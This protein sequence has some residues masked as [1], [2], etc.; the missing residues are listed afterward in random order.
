MILKAALA[1]FL[2]VL[3]WS[4]LEYCIHRWLGHDRRF[5]PN[6]F[7]KEH[8]RHHIEGDYFAP[9]YKKAAAALATITLTGVP[10]V[11]LAGLWPGLAYAAGLTSMYLAYE[12]LHRLE[13]VHAGRGPY[14]RWARK[15]HFYHHFVDARYNHGVTSPVWDLVFGT[16]RTIEVIEVP[17]RLMMEWLGT[18]ETGVKPELA[19]S[20]AL[21]VSK[22]KKRKQAEA[23]ADEARSAPA[24]EARA[25]AV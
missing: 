7:A 18:P 20:Y 17:P 8:I 16:Y 15:H 12:L 2:G 24:S 1:M 10:A 14:G 23:R 11:L 13:H 22:H 19:G 3:T 6:L 5:R 25:A 4:L 9:A 21:K